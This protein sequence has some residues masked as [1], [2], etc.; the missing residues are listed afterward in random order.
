MTPYSFWQQGK[1]GGEE[2][3]PRWQTSGSSDFAGV[4]ARAWRGGGNE[5]NYLVVIYVRQCIVQ[6][7]VGRFVLLAELV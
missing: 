6:G 3:G 5:E 4:G 2:S 1:R 7:A